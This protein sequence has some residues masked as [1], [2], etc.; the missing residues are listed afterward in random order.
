ME[1]ITRSRKP[2]NWTRKR[3][4]R[5]LEV[6]GLRQ[7]DLVRRIGKSQSL[8]SEVVSGQLKSLPVASVVAEALGLQPHDIWPRIYA[9][10]A[11]EP[12]TSTDAPMTEP[13]LAPVCRAS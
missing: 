11:P 3:I 5:E 13:N 12:A 9:A 4:N 8:V 2:R 10:P 7:A 6:R 1:P